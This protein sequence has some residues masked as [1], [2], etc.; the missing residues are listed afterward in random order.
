MGAG[1][2]LVKWH[3]LSVIKLSSGGLT[4]RMVIIVNNTVLYAGKL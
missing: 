2:K 4:Y 1:E 3:K